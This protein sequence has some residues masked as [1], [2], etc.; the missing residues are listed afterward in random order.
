MTTIR[1]LPFYKVG[2]FY[3][4]AQDLNNKTGYPI[5]LIHLSHLGF[6]QVTG[7]ETK[8]LLQG[9]LT[10]NLDD[11]SASQSRLGAHC[12][13]QGRILSLFHLFWYQDSYYLQMPVDVIPEALAALK[14]YAAFFKVQL[15]EA[16][17]Q[18]ICMSGTAT[19]LA[20]YFTALP[21]NINDVIAT[22]EAFIT[23]LPGEPPHYSVITTP[24]ASTRFTTLTTPADASNLW[25]LRNISAGIP[26]LYPATI[27]KLLPH[28]INLPAL[29]AVSF[30]KGCYT[31]QEIITR[32]HYRGQLKKHLRRAR[33][34]TASAP[35][36]GATIYTTGPAGII[37]D[38]CQEDATTYQILAII[39]QQDTQLF[40]DP[41]KRN[42]LEL[43]S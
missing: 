17:S 25:K 37:V 18:L 22:D 41:D 28:E 10:C 6:I 12:N 16:S 21:E 34:H 5:M 7:P 20:P 8:K 30:N 38:S 39:N 1:L 36:P 9:Q 23:K 40:L 13:P 27:G 14:K 3:I 31:G 15:Q 19:D 11:I 29:N 42:P 32:M 43:I 26:S 33:V 2:V 35:E 4:I 24:A